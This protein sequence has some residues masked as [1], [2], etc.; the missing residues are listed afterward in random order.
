MKFANV[1]FSEN[2]IISKDF[3]DTY[4]SKNGAI[5]EKQYVF[6]TQ[7]RIPQIWQN[8]EKIVI[9]ENGF[10]LGINFLLTY[11]A[12]VNDTQSAKKLLYYTFDLYPLK[13][14]DL[15]KVYEN[16]SELK[17]FAYKLLEKYANLKDGV[18]RFVFEDGNITLILI[19]DEALNS[20]KKFEKI[21]IWFLD[22][23]APSKNMDIYR[24]EVFDEIRNR[25]NKEA[26]FST[27]SCAGVI[28]SGMQKA[29]FETSKTKGFGE[30]KHM[31][32][33]KFKE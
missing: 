9:G 29:G 20:L 19:I 18:N 3:D 28:K 24:D 13:F 25:S 6:L 30:K 11:K 4:F 10:G 7:N 16:L 8:R 21:D 14:E 12:F 27:Y 32:Q 2:S 33:G 26:I 22:G 5:E 31:L 1:V 15:K 17:P 23:F